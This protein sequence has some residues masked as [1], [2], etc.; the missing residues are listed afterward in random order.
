MTPLYWLQTHALDVSFIGI[1]DTGRRS[2]ILSGV[3]QFVDQHGMKKRYPGFR[4]ASYMIGDVA[5]SQSR[6]SCLGPEYA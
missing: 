4:S 3:V 6:G 5:R 1:S 2:Q